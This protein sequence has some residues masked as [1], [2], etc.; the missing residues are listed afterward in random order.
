[1]LN[2]SE[3]KISHNNVSVQAESKPQM[4]FEARNLDSHKVDMSPNFK[5]ESKQASPQVSRVIEGGATREPYVEH[6]F[7]QFPVPQPQAPFEQFQTAQPYVE[8]VP[9]Q[10]TV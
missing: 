1:M 6:V 2:D 7:T 5:Q 3:A 10:Q 9:G 4:Y 8:Y